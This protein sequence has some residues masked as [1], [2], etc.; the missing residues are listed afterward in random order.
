LS[1]TAEGEKAFFAW[2]DEP[3]ASS[4]R[5]LHLEF[6]ARLY[7]ASHIAPSRVPELIQA[8]S[9]VLIADLFRLE[10][11]QSSRSLSASE[12]TAPSQ[13]PNGSLD[14]ASIGRYSSDFRCRQLRAALVWLEETVSRQNS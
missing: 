13:A 1:V 9:E 3:T 5:L 4:P 12:P 10:A 6:L 11:S 8:Q 14:S 7:F 2:R